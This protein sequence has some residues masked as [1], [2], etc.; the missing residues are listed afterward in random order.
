[1]LILIYKNQ[2]SPPLPL[3]KNMNIFLNITSGYGRDGYG[4]ESKVY[5]NLF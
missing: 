1:M 4:R 3:V 2:K 5:E